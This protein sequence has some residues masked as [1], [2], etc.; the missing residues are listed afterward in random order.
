MVKTNWIYMKETVFTLFLHSLEFVKLFTHI[1][2]K[3][4]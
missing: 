4:F 2:K 1:Q 3:L